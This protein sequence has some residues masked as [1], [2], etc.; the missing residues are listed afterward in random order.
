MR[1]IILIS[2]KWVLPVVALFIVSI[3]ANAQKLPTV[4]KVSLR[5][6]TNI[7]IDGQ[8]TEWDNKLQAYNNATD[9]F[10]TIAND[11]E[12]LYLTVRATKP[13]IIQ[14][15]IAVGIGFTINNLARKNDK[16]SENITV[17]YPF[18]EFKTGEN[19]ISTVGLKSVNII[20][21]LTDT[22]AETAFVR[23]K[24]DSLIIIANKMFENQSKIIKIKGLIGITDTL[25]SV[26]NE[27]SIRVAG[28]FDNTKAYTLEVAIPL[29]HL[30]LSI[31]NLSKFSYNIKLISRFDANKGIVRTYYRYGSAGDQIDMNADL[32]S[33]TDFWGDYT[34]VKK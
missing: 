17:T 7:K 10:Y 15:I 19:I 31:D 29:K 2:A 11:D 9:I 12:N 30:G 33:T 18:L 20:P 26:Y 25:I 27:Q 24:A 28:L 23:K 8:A 22:T 6:P 5:A 21:G 1:N 13:R 3:T 32:D 14:K 16:A 34:L 4:Q